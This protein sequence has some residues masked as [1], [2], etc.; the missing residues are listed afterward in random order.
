MNTT[1]C[2]CGK[3]MS[4]YARQCAACHTARMTELAAQGRAVVA[5]GKCPDCGSPLAQ[6]FSM[7]GWYQC[8]AYPAPSH[9]KAE[10]LRLPKCNFQVTIPEVQS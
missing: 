1:R 2:G 5:T 9:R 8:V 4:K 3:R 6:N 10:F 7:T